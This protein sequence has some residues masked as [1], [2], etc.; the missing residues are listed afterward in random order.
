MRERA[1]VKHGQSSNDGVTSDA[2]VMMDVFDS[3]N[4][5]RNGPQMLKVS[6]RVR[7]RES[8]GREQNG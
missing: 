8:V 2:G 7:F 4:V 5:E 6:N 3:I 1:D